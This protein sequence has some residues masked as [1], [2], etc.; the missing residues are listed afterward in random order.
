[1][2]IASINASG[3]LLFPPDFGQPSPA[4]KTGTG[5]AGLV[6]QFLAKIN[7]QQTGA[8]Q[9]VKDLA[10]GKTDNLHGVVLQVAKADLSFRMVMQIRNR[11]SDALQ[12]VLRM[13]V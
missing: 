7:A 10:L 1:M 2:A 5:F 8:D 13:A 12:E 4:G 9:A 3:P 6:D 11:L